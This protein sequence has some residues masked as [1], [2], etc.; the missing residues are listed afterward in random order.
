MGYGSK[1][2]ELLQKYYEMKMPSL[3]DYN[4]DRAAD[5]EPVADSDV[6][7]LEEQIGPRR[8]LP[9]LLLKLSERRPERLDYL[10]VSFGVTQDLLRF[11]KRAGFAPTYLRQTANELTGEHSMIMLKVLSHANQ[12]WL[13]MFWADFRKRCYTV[14]IL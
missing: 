10:G 11:W 7:L 13:P 2:L 1:A 8:N 12:E 5:I 6:T 3:D 4:E 9:P 14:L